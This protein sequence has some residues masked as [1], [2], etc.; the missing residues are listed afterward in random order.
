MT[1]ILIEALCWMPTHVH[2]RPDYGSRLDT[3]DEVAYLASRTLV[4]STL[5]AGVGRAF[6]K[7]G[8]SSAAPVPSDYQYQ[9]P[10]V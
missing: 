10:E 2:R 7:V 8:G 4:N 5:H 1:F 6:G 3:G 9:D